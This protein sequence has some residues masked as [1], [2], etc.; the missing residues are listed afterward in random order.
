M[1]V[2]LFYVTFCTVSG[3]HYRAI[4]RDNA[5]RIYKL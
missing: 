2:E 5:A 1:S 4:A 3:R